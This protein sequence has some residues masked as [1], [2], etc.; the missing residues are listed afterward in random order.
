MFAGNYNLMNVS[1]IV[2][3]AETIAT[4]G[5][6]TPD[7]DCAGSNLAFYNYLKK[8]GKTVDV[9]LE[10]LPKTFSGLSGFEL[11]KNK[12]TDKVYDLFI[13]FDCGEIERI[14][15]AGKM[16]KN[17]KKTVCIDH[18]VTSKG[19]A[20]L[21]FIKPTLSSACEV[22]FE[23]MDP[24]LIDKETAEC[25]YMGIIHDTGVFHHLSTSKRTMEIAGILME[26]GIDFPNIIDKSFYQKTYKQNQ[27]LGRC[28]LESLLLWNGLAV[29]SYLTLKEVE[30]YQVG[31]DDLGGIIDQLRLTEG[32]KVA[33]F[34]HEIVPHKFKVSLRS[35]APDIEVSRICE[36]FGGGGHKM[37]AG[38]TIAGGKVHDV[39]NNVTT[40]LQQLFVEKGYL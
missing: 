2:K 31:N 18:H 37:A 34:I 32:V 1:D 29:V 22:L 8:A 20:D 30:F 17:A 27:V 10:K 40:Q 6:I 21:N 38:C 23:M 15:F 4:S 7:G 13:M 12:A 28:L 36:F 19:I 11:V 5:H 35:N 14:G 16:F 9:Y 25:L 33:I 39:I 26:K 24:D 3:D